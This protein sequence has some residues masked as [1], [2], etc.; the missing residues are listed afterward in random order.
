[1]IP[2]AM[3]IEDFDEMDNHIT[4]PIVEKINQSPKRDTVVKSKEHCD[5][6]SIANRDPRQKL[7]MD[8]FT[9]QRMKTADERSR[10]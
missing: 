2:N 1:M 10:K 5:F 3:M 6:S 4:T 9:D 8:Q 7:N